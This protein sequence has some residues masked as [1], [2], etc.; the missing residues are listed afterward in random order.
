MRR[1]RKRG[2]KQRNPWAPERR[3]A[4]DRSS[5]TKIHPAAKKRNPAPLGREA[6]EDH[7]S[8]ESPQ[9]IAFLVRDT[10]GGVRRH[11]TSHKRERVVG[12]VPRGYMSPV[13]VRIPPR[14]W[15]IRRFGCAHSAVRPPPSQ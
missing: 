5:R 9:R 6:F 11:A 3:D 14:D 8:L 12:V 13:L 15:P 1:K 10:S 4:S 2:N 7:A